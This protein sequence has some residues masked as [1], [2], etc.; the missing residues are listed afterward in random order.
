MDSPDLEKLTGGRFDPLTDAERTLLRAAVAGTSAKCGNPAKDDDPEDDPIRSDSWTDRRNIRAGLIQ[1]L[2]LDGEASK[3]VDHEGVRIDSAGIIDELHLCYSAVPFPLR[4]RRCRILEDVYLSSCEIPELSMEHT[5]SRSVFADNATIKGNAFF[6]DRFHADG[7]L[8]LRGAH[9][10]GDISCMGGHFINPGGAAVNLEC[11]TVELR[12]FLSGGFH[13]EG[14]VILTS[15]TINGGLTCDGGIFHNPAEPAFPPDPGAADQ[16]GSGPAEYAGVALDARESKIGGAVFLSTAFEAMGMVDLRTAKIAGPLICNGGRFRNPPSQ[17]GG[18][19]IALYADGATIENMVAL[20]GSFAEGQVRGVGMKIGTDLICEGSQFLN[21]NGGE[22]L[23]I[24][25]SEIQ[26]SVYLY[27]GFRAEGAVMMTGAHIGGDLICR[28]GTIIRPDGLALSIDSAHI[29]ARFMMCEGFQTEGAVSLGN[30][31]IGG[32]VYCANVTLRHGVPQNAKAGAS[33]VSQ[34]LYAGIALNA[35]CAEVGGYVLLSPGFHAEG[36]VVLNGAHIG[37]DLNCAGATLSCPNGCAL[38]LDN[39]HVTSQVFL[40]LGFHAEGM[41]SLVGAQI[42]GNL[43]CDNA[44]FFHGATPD[45]RS[46]DAADSE[47]SR[48]PFAGLALNAPGADISGD[49][50]LTPGFQAQGTVFLRTAKIRGALACSGARILRATVKMA[51]GVTPRYSGMAL[52]GDGLSVGDTM[53]L[54][55]GFMAEGLTTLAGARIGVHLRFSGSEFRNPG[56]VALWLA[57]SCTAG[58]LFLNSAIEGQVVFSRASVGSVLINLEGWQPGS[59]FLD[60]FTYSQ[61]RS[62]P[63]DLEARLGWLALQSDDSFGT[64]PYQQMAKVLA[65][66]GDGRSAQRVRYQM[67]KQ[68]RSVARRNLRTRVVLLEQAKQ[69]PDGALPGEPAAQATGEAQFKGAETPSELRR[70]AGWAAVWDYLYGMIVGYGYYAWRAVGGLVVMALLGMAFFWAGYRHG[71]MIP[72]DAAAAA[73]FVSSRQPP[74]SY[75]HFHALAYSAE[76]TFPLV[77]LGQTDRWGPN[78]NQRGLSSWGGGL[79][80]FQWGQIVLGWIFATFFVA[81]VTGIVRRS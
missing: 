67:E 66:A 43:Q 46:E 38:A 28:R 26:G 64:Q 77:K 62:L 65:A 33:G 3:L 81:G 55:E 41:V 70:R 7:T 71:G 53:F 47:G 45:S 74:A 8:I 37:A 40:N 63:D 57:G 4:F 79:R 23:Q 31:Q 44:T 78:P 6:G 15:A 72:T 29:T 18:G 56:G 17:N 30:A 75:E 20:R 51:P 22:A 48:L 2:C 14:A 50:I 5:R 10:G 11:A 36:M 34:D 73:T 16:A 35:P 21:K 49:M 1:W 27:E 13:A 68:A 59:L 12:A 80:W 24:S 19:G 69:S 42:G 52:M 60:G 76:N 9:I 61:F 25:A 54:D 39:A 32:N 58:D